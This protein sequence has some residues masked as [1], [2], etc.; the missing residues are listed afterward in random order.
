MLAILRSNLATMRKALAT[1]R[2]E[3]AKVRSPVPPVRKVYGDDAQGLWQSA[4]MFRGEAAQV[5]GGL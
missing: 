4:L 5:N 1:L 3:L 2:S